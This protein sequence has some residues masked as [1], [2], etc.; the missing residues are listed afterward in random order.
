MRGNLRIPRERSRL[1]LGKIGSGK[2]DGVDLF[3]PSSLDL[4][5]STHRSI[6]DSEE[7]KFYSLKN[8]LAGA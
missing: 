5:V 6:L 1:G 7:F 8:Q 3:V 2:I 4:I